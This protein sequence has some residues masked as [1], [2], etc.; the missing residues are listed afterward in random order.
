MD[1]V[2]RLLGSLCVALVSAPIV[3]ELGH[4][5]AA[6]MVSA[7]QVRIVWV[8]PLR[9]R[10]TAVLG[11]DVKV[12]LHAARLRFV[13][14][15]PLANGAVA[16][17]AVATCSGVGAVVALVHAGLAATTLW[18]S[19]QSDGAQLVAL[20]RTRRAQRIVVDDNDVG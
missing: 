11:D 13:L 1:D 8:A 15:G 20:L 10:T 6:W 4:A 12:G 7:Q 17:C 18:P 3:H 9:L 5:A 14:G 19:Q 2:V 16:L